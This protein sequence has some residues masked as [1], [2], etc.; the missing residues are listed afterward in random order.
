VKRRPF[1][2]S[3]SAGAAV[4]AAPA[5]A[6]PAPWPSRA[7]RMIIPF[8]TGGTTDIAGRLVAQRLAE[9]LGVPVV[10]E[11]K[12]GA[13]GTTGTELGAKAPPDGYTL[14]LGNSG[15]LSIGPTIYP[16]LGYDVA[17]DLA[18]ITMIA[19]TTN[20]FVVHPSVPAKSLKELVALAKARADKPMTVAIAAV[21]SI[22]HLLVEQL[23]LEAGIKLVGVP[24]KGGGQ[25]VIDILAGNIDINVDNIPAQLQY[26][27]GG[28]LRA[29]AVSSTQ[30]SEQLPDVP[31]VIEEGYPSLVSSPWFTMLAPA[32][33]PQPILDRLN[34]ELVAIMQSD[35]MKQR[36][37][38][39]AA[40][41]LW[42]TPDEA[43]RFIAAETA[44]WARVIKESGAKL[45]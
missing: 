45:E 14:V 36:L 28:R 1:L 10:V 27:R 38:A 32:K 34:K 2:A 12:P 16:N 33:T 7:I 43:S 17:R 15:A 26:V 23:K 37:T 24:Y 22:A 40:N 11:N 21:G 44:R 18:P 6:Q 41:A 29:I 5:L 19:D 20:L 42:S 3:L 4:A 9:R 35:D 39:A 31:T 13:G 25:A 30:R 8:P